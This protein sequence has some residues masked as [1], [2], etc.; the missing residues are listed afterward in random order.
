MQP[1]VRSQS[2]YPRF[3]TQLIGNRPF[4]SLRYASTK[5]V[6]AR[7]SKLA[8]AGPGVKSAPK[9]QARAF[10]SSSVPASKKEDFYTILGVSRSST[11][12]EIKKS[13]R[14][15]AMQYHP[16][17]N[18]DP[19]AQDKFKSIT[20]AYTVLSDE[21][22][23]RTYDQF[24]EEGVNQGFGAHGG[25]GGMSAEEIFSQMFGGGFPGGMGGMGGD[26]GG[27]GGMGGQMEKRTPDM[28]HVISVTLEDVFAGKSTHIEFTKQ[29]NCGT[30][31]GSGAKPPH[32]PTKC[33]A[34]R[35]SGQ[36]VITR[37]MGGMIQQSIGECPT[38]HGAGETIPAGHKCSDCHGHKVTSK[39]QRLN[40]NIPKG[41]KN[42]DVLNF[43]GEANQHPGAT[44][45]DVRVHID[46]KPHPIFKRLKNED[47]LVEQT[48]SLGNA[49]SGYEFTIQTLD[50][51]LLV[52]RDLYGKV[53]SKVI[54]P[55]TI[56]MIPN[57]GLP[58]RAGR[59][60]NLYIRFKVDFP[61]GAMINPET[62]A[63]ALK[64]ARQTAHIPTTAS[65]AP[66]PGTTTVTLQD[67]PKSFTP[68]EEVAA[69]QKRQKRRSSS[70]QGGGQEAQCAQM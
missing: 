47:L 45:G 70:N 63:P 9:I 6:F 58:N 42:G 11:P 17:R 69:Q 31:R 43:P 28:E 2:R 36:R 61:D 15:L 8:Y 23:R 65:P 35:G 12:D 49:L 20:E 1:Q 59:R 46:V 7:S 3:S 19:S 25:M 26:F 4:S 48:I 62:L 54:S 21:N 13:Y 44:T 50:K 27:F 5:S 67:V 10:H 66:P 39:N 22:K 57:E 51:R 34:C 14:K 56:K 38:C 55:G 53:G 68:E 33:S 52:V 24:G 41:A 32:K 37:Q 60:G 29:V 30:C 18:P 40:I 64:E 16:D